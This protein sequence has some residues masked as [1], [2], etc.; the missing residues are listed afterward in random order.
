MSKP[1]GNLALTLGVM[2]PADWLARQD[3]DPHLLPTLDFLLVHGR[4]AEAIAC[5]QAHV[6]RTA[7]ARWLCDHPHPEREQ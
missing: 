6:E 4:F 1:A 2:T 7:Y 3:N 5:L